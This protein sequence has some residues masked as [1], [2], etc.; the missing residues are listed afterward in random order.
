MEYNHMQR[1]SWHYILFAV[2]AVMLA[3]A[4]VARDE[5]WAMDLNL[6]VAVLFVALAMMFGSLTVRDEGQWLALRYGPLPMF[7]K[8]IRYDKITAVEPD[9]TKII[10]GWGIHYIPGRG[11]TYNLWGFDCTR[12]SLGK[13]IIRVGTDDADNLVKFL[14]GKVLA[15]GLSAMP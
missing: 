12:L 15:D 1:G 2:A 4:W 3:A 14:K 5:V 8:R 11:W 9:R 10:D 13:K 7:R 6:A